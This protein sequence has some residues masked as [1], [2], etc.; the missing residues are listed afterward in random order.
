[1]GSV[2]GPPHQAEAEG[3]ALSVWQL[4]EYQREQPELEDLK[5]TAAEKAGTRW[6]SKRTQCPKSNSTG[7]S[8]SSKIAAEG[9]A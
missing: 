3:E 7:P 8:Q 5:Y 9:G 2:S 4:C 6:K 1:M